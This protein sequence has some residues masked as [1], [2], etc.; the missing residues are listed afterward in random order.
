MA[1][2]VKDSGEDVNKAVTAQRVSS[3]RVA[4]KPCGLVHRGRI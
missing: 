4:G 3:P 1:A 2:K